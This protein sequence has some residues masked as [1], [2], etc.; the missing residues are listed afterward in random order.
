[1][2]RSGSPVWAATGVKIA[3]TLAIHDI[4][5]DWNCAK[6][7]NRIDARHF[8]AKGIQW[9]SSSRTGTPGNWKDL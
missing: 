5:L 6:R 3:I 2:A 1:M 4:F 7:M 9:V 8:D